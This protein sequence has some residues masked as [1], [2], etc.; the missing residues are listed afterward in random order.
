MNNKLRL[1]L[2]LIDIKDI[3]IDIG[4]NDLVNRLNEVIKDLENEKVTKD[5]NK[6]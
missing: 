5:N 1:I 6:R 4:D 2:H 3:L